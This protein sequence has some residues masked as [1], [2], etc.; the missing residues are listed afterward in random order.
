M[1]QPPAAVRDAADLPPLVAGER[2]VRSLR[3]FKIAPSPVGENIARGKPVTASSSVT[4]GGVSYP[5]ANAVDGESE[6][7]WS[8]EFADPA[9]LMVDLGELIRIRRVTIDWQTAC[10]KAFA[11]QVSADGKAWTD[12]FKTDS[13]AGGATEIDFTPVAARYVRIYGT[14]RGTKWGYAICEL[15][16]FRE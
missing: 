15:M 1:A 11:V 12:V 3:D 10:A 2:P 8:S 4:V 16:V 14:A 5:V 13:G 6:T 7:Y 9:W